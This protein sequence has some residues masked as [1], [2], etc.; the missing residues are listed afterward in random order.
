MRYLISA[1]LLLL[2]VILFD[3]PALINRSELINNNYSVI[4]ATSP[5]PN[6]DNSM[7]SSSSSSPA[8]SLTPTKVEENSNTTDNQNT[9][10]PG[11]NTTNQ[12]NGNTNSN[13]SIPHPSVPIV[14]TPFVVSSSK[15]VDKYYNPFSPTGLVEL[16]N[17]HNFYKES[18]Y[19]PYIKTVLVLISLVLF[20]LGIQLIDKSKIV[21][22]QNLRNRIILK[23]ERDKKL[24]QSYY[25]G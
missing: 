23:K 2:L 21:F 7:P 18:I 6:L 4:A 1:L 25:E 19:S 8:A 13:I 20:I 16:F 5:A 14:I 9:N 24:L 15:V 22:I 12:T 11:Q 3:I 10:N 17:P